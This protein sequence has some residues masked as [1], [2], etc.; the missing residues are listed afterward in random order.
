MEYRAGLNQVEPLADRMQAALHGATRIHVG[1]AYAKTSGVSHLL[2]IGPPA[3]SRA[4][5]GLG[6]GVTDPQA[7]EQLDHAGLD[8]RVV[9]DGSALSSAQFHPKLYLV[10]RPGQ[11]VTLSGSA[12][13]TGAGWT[14][15]VEQFEELVHP[16]P[17]TAADQQRH[18]FEAI[19]DHGSPL[20]LLRR[21]GDW[22]LYRQRARDRRL[23][24]RQD[25]RRL[26]KL[27][28]R[29]GQL[30]GRLA[31][32]PTRAN[33]GYIAITND[34]WWEFQLR[35]RDGADRALFW[36]RNTN[37]FRA[38]AKDGVFFHLVKDPTAPEELRAIR[39]YSVFSGD[40]EVADSRDAFRRYGD[41]LGVAT[42]EQ[43]YDRLDITPGLDIGI[44]HLEA[45]T[46]LERPV[47]LAELRANGVPFA[48]NIVAGKSI[49][50]AQVA[51]M[52]ELGGLGAREGIVA[53]AAEEGEPYR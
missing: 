32:G 9:A 42:L 44:I 27:Q 17:S 46:E 11:L 12:N 53:V 33:P 10:E 38:L 34:G 45:L 26:L 43:L 15:N 7:V 14:S 8:V 19:W 48:G 25:R 52:F 23:L 16:D 41:L 5:V 20:S 22:D 28:G 49:D 13:L 2:R 1:V 36:R 40:Y 47:T 24:E 6:F 3:G 21:S 4:V 50:L 30:V 29:T 39:G 51:T 31:N 18:R 37:Q 35:Q